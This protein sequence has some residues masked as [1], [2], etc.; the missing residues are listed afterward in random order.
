[1]EKKYPIRYIYGD[2]AG[3]QVQASVGVGEA[4]IFYQLTGHRVRGLRDRA[5]KSINSGVS[6]LRSFILSKDG[7][8][9][10]LIDNSCR[11]LI[12]DMDS[13]RYPDT[14]DGRPIRDVPLKTDGV[15]HSMDA[16]RYLVVNH[17]PIR[18]YKYRTGNDIQSS[19]TNY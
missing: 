7:S 14:P 5:S 17:T 4:D 16:L 11:G 18:Q 10:L 15:D 8:R 13:Y 2:P 12:T 1:M 6:H 3:Y 9:R 19:R